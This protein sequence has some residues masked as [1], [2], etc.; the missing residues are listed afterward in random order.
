MYTQ[1]QNKM[2]NAF[3]LRNPFSYMELIS[4][5]SCEQIHGCIDTRKTCTVF[6]DIVFLHCSVI[7]ELWHNDLNDINLDQ[8]QF[9]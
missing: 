3:F 8:H 2:K 9:I 1:A 4:T 5:K 6:I 7:F